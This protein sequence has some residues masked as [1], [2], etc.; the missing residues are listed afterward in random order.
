MQIRSWSTCCALTSIAITLV[1]CEFPQSTGPVTAD[2]G[3]TAHVEALSALNLGGPFP[4]LR[5]DELARFEAGEDEFDEVETVED[6]L[7][8]V[9]NEA[10]CSTCHTN[11]IGGSERRL[12]PPLRKAGPA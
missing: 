1:G 11:P 9:F 7:G 2:S 10:A 3:F 12:R 5:P 6:G 4:K 8:P